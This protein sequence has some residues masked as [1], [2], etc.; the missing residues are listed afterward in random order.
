M[1]AK[2]IIT[3]LISFA[4]CMLIIW[5]IALGINTPMISFQSGNMSFQL[6]FAATCINTFLILL[7]GA[8]LYQRDKK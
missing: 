5:G 4:V 7:L 1:K 8:Y 2:V 3:A 6:I